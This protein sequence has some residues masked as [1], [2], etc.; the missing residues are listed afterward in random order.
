MLVLNGHNIAFC[1][2]DVLQKGY[3]NVG[4]S[5]FT[6]DFIMHFLPSLI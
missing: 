2:F 4:P 3:T 1:V 5:K 6:T